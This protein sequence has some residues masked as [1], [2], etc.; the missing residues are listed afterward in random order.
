MF[1]S[2]DDHLQNSL[3]DST[4]WMNPSIRKKLENSWAPVF[5]EHVFSKIDEA[6]FAV[7]YSEIGRPNF[8]INYLLSLEYIKHMR[9]DSDE[10]LI[11]SFYFDYL[12][13]YA[14]GIKTL[15]EKN[16]AP[17]TLYYFRKRI[18]D[19]LLNNPDKEDL[20]FGQFINL[21]ETF[22]KEAGTSLD[23][24]RTDTT[25]FKSNIKKA[26]RMSLAYDVLREAIK[27]IPEEQMTENLKNA[28]SSTFKRDL[29]YL[30]KANETDTKLTLVLNLC[31][32]ALD[33]L[34]NVP[35]MKESSQ[36]RILTRFLNE[37]SVCDPDNDK[38]IPKSKKDI[39]SD[40]LQSAYDEDA[41]FRTKGKVSQSGYALEVS[42]T[43]SKDN[44]F[45]LITD[46]DVAPNNTSDVEMFENRI[47][48]IS[49][50]TGCKDMYLDGSF[51]SHE[52]HKKANENGMN[53]H[54]TNMSGTEP[55]KK[56]SLTEF[57]IDPVTSLIISCPKGHTGYH[58]S[59]SGS[60]TSV[61]YSVDVCSNCEMFD[62]CHSK[63]QKKD[64]VVRISLNSW[65][66]AKIRCKMMNEKVE[67]T[68]M[69]AAVEG[70]C[71][72]L[73]RMGQDKL[74]VRGKTKVKVFSGYNCCAQ[75]IKR[76]IKFKL[77]GYKLK[78]EEATNQ[79]SIAFS[80]S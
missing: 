78:K 43:C 22:A 52:L 58:A 12:V 31:R 57:E 63:K 79:G 48:D 67:N 33:I 42:E 61:H 38:L 15:G 77:G 21:V 32:E 71:S 13:N 25:L 56:V 47:E 17:R 18:Y 19:Y 49:K 34:L 54:L 14:L 44:P 29:L 75:N 2:N 50:N 62:I 26:G 36:V 20:L 60:Q 35:S 27:A 41:T 66:T 37:Q 1:K 65:N 64:Y 5:Y 51:H 16:L 30:C 23:K 59:A 24:Q 80:F 53:I 39:S 7:L 4:Q 74:P 68:S 10:S 46:Y 9:A 11:E 72:S 73:K 3:F 76:F 55:V 45:Q 70:T 69:R 8:A 28:T 40:S 6:P